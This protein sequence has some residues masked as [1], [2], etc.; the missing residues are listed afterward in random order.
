LDWFKKVNDTYGHDAG[1]RVLR[2]VTEVV[3][4]VIRRTDTLG[5]WGGEEF[6]IICPESSLKTGKTVAQKVRNA[7]G[8]HTF[9]HNLRITLSMG[10]TEYAEDMSPREMLLDVDRKL[11][12][13]KKQGR[14]MVVG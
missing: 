10:I 1:D 5:R 7:L 14:D 12:Q 13:A 8:S 6:M 9:P 11:Y 2:E 3:Q 4:S